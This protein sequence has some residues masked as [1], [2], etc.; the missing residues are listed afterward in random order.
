MLMSILEK[1]G[2]KVEINGDL[3]IARITDLTKD[4]ISRH[5]FLVGRL[6]GFARQ[7]DVLLK[8]DGDI[9]YYIEKFTIQMKAV[10]ENR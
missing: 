9:D 10:N 4:E 5:L 7:L 6:I 1:D 3:V 2:F 8:N